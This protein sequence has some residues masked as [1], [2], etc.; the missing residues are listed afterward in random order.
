[1]RNERRAAK[2]ASTEKTKELKAFTKRVARLQ[3]R[4]ALLGHPRGHL[5]RHL[6]GHLLHGA[7]RNIHKWNISNVTDIEFMFNGASSFNQPIG[8]WNTSNVT[9]MDG[10]FNAASSFNQFAVGAPEK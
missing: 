6:L 9:N 3:A 1:M 8:K 4:A 2:K 10:M 7:L 5:L